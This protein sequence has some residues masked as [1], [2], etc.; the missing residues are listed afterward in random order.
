MIHLFS[1]LI[2]ASICLS[3][4]YL[5]YVLLI[6]GDTFYRLKRYYLLFTVAV[7]L[8]IPQLPALQPS[9]IISQKTELS[10]GKPADFSGYNDSFEKLVVGNFPV[11]IRTSDTSGNTITFQYILLAV[12]F[13]GV[14]YLLYRLL[15]NLK[16]I[17]RII[18]N[19]SREPYRKYTIVHHSDDYP[20]FSFLTFIFLNSN[21]LNN[22][23]KD[24]VLKHEEV[25]IDQKHSFDILF[26]EL[27]KIVLWFN[28]V[29]WLLK[30]S[31]VKV[32]ECQADDYIIRSGKEDVTNYQSL[33]LKQYLGNI[34]LEL[35]HPF[36]YSLIKFRINMM[37]KER[38]VRLAKVKFIL[39]IPVLIFC[40]SAFTN[41]GIK[42][43]STDNI[44]SGSTKKLHEPE[45][46]GMAYIPSGSFVLNR[47]DGTII[48]SLNVTIEAFWMNQTEVS[49]KE[50]FEYTESVKMDSTEQ[51]YERALPDKSKAPF[52]DYY[53][54]KKYSEFPVLGVSLVQAIDF[55][56]WKTR[57]ENQKL[58][59]KGKPPVQAYRIP[60]DFEWVYS[61]FGGMSPDKVIK[62]VINGLVKPAKSKPNEWGLY[63]MFDNASEWTCTAFDPET[64]MTKYQNYPLTSMT[65][66]IVEGNNYK[67][68]MVSDKTVLNCTES[69]DYVG[70]RYVR[71]YMG[72]TYGKK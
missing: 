45:P 23:E 32:H 66:V 2:E 17:L 47:N 49:V 8:L 41:V 15:L 5:V 56:K 36:N 21:N 63:N 48:R 52:A 31:L 65:S 59:N 13:S 60:T 51:V 19:N 6:I 29:I 12:Y 27:C 34:N 58:K 18:K 20:T 37:T 71:T 62:P 64:Y 22:T 50:Y 46:Y 4:F 43:S 61:S 9:K 33:L 69:Y 70:F 11:A 54:N 44:S 14:L 39:A 25:H 53:S 30:K 38:S 3:L 67:N 68:S 57:I 24:T 72:S 10:A 55:C 28:P 42:S 35:A 26:I 40:F 7:S 1:Y 16:Q